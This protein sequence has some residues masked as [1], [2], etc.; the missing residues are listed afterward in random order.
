MTELQK[1]MVEDLQLRGM[2]EKTQESYLRAVRKL[3]ERY[4]K[5]PDEITEEEL[6][7]YFLYLKNE[8]KYSRSASTVA[9]CGIKFFYDHTIKKEWPTLTF[10]RAPRQ[11]KLPVILTCEEVR[12]ILHCIRLP[13]YRACLTTIYSC[14]L[15][16][17]EGCRLKVADIDSSRMQIHVRGGKGGKDRYVPLPRNTLAMLRKFWVTHRNPVFIFPAPGRGGIDMPRAKESIPRSSVQIAFKEA[18]KQSRIN[19]L[20][21]VHTLRHSWATHLLEASVHLRQIQEYLGHG[22]PSTTAIYTHL[23]QKAEQMAKVAIDRIMDD[24]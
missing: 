20:A 19:K 23:T 6:R 15:R 16:L 8:K 4:H 22:S 10:I 17:G 18:L 21:T 7:Q 9:L 12:E 13:H 1:R 5:S 24:L 14:G 3:E 11:K 2:S